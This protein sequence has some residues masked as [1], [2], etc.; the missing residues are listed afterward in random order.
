MLEIEL[1]TQP[2]RSLQSWELVGKVERALKPPF[3]A[4]SIREAEAPLYVS[5]YQSRLRESKT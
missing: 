4:N 1:S 5:L 3:N 2:H